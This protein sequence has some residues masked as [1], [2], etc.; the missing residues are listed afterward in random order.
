MTADIQP[1][2]TAAETALAE[3]FARFKQPLPA[4]E[5]ARRDAAFAEFHKAG[6]PHRRVEEWK[7]TDLR[8]AMREA[9]PLAEPNSAAV[10]AMA[11]TAIAQFGSLGA[12]R[13]V[14]VNGQYVQDLAQAADGVEI[15][16][17]AAALTES[18]DLLASLGQSGAPA[19]NTAVALNNA[20]ASDGVLVRMSS[21]T[22]TTLHLALHQE[23][24]HASYTRIVVA[25]DAGA[26]VELIET[27]TG[28]GAHQ[29]NTM[30]EIL[31]GEGAR[32]AHY[33]LQ[34]ES[35]ETLHLA[36]LA[37]KLEGGVN[38][39]STALTKGANLARQQIFLTFAGEHSEAVLGG[40]SLAGARRHLDTT[41]FV[42]HAVPNCASRERYK[43]VLTDDARG[44][45]QGKILVR[46]DAQKT[47]GQMKSDALLLSE[48]A[49]MDLKPELEIYADDVV[50][51]HGA[52]A[53]AIDDEL[54]FYLM[55]RG[56]PRAEAETL[57]I[58]AFAGEVF[59]GIENDAVR[60]IFVASAQNWLSNRG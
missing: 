45:F 16:P 13:A 56:I 4:G 25:V 24:D 46:R 7:Y 30:V 9:K 34:D 31:V 53:G 11:K 20:F 37:A 5:I 23:G 41:L 15:T 19:S 42:D 21:R 58:T 3:A 10:V 48:S 26:E 22:K 2:R 51:A 12:A 36:T 44:V 38:F 17:L 29:T 50:C 39:S 55:A 60:D 54:L 43:T 33:K 59:E 8:A 40:V 28:S 1:I 52:T 27:H 47:D 57:M 6:L 18:S 32:V 49:E 14:I 35:R